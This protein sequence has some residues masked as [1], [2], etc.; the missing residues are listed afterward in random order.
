[1]QEDAIKPIVGQRFDIDEDNYV[2]S[3]VRNPN[4]RHAFLILEGVNEEGEQVA[5]HMHLITKKGSTN[6]LDQLLTE[7]WVGGKSVFAYPLWTIKKVAS[8]APLPLQKTEITITPMKD[9]ANWEYLNL[10]AREYVYRSYS[11]TSKQAEKLLSSVKEDIAA[12]NIYYNFSGDGSAHS[13]SF[14]G[15]PHHS[16]LS[17]AKRKLIDIDVPLAGKWYN[18]LIVIPELEIPKD[19]TSNAPS[20]G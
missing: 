14:S 8:D 15:K 1:M 20:N 12:D 18:W 11:I 19:S 13:G 6:T 17:W 16:C 9:R 3:Y 7:K 4:N 5:W 2:V 10:I